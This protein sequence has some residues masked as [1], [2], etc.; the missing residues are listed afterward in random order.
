MS[1]IYEQYLLKY[2]EYH[3]T[4][5][6][7]D[8]KIIKRRANLLFRFT[9]KFRQ[10]SF[11]HRPLRDNSRPH[12]IWDFRQVRADFKR[13][14]AGKHIQS[15]DA[16][17]ISEVSS[18][19][20]EI[21]DIKNREVSS[22]KHI[23]LFAVSCLTLYF[24]TPL[25]SLLVYLFPIPAFFFGF[26]IFREYQ[27][28]IFDI[29]TYIRQVEFE[30]IEDGGWVNYFFQERRMDKYFESRVWFWYASMAMY[31]I[32]GILGHLLLER[33]QPFDGFKVWQLMWEWSHYSL[34]EA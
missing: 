30:F 21:I 2:F 33:A 1:E 34:V 9:R 25:N 24:T 29:D 6:N 22:E 7:Y 15:A 31:V 14:G 8:V 11:A 17:L 10:P 4:E 19:R 26:L 5:E 27:R 23:S 16:Y 3:T 18:L 20:A 28:N 12:P 32:A 13:V